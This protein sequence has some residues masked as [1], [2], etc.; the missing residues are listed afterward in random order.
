ML[1]VSI[2]CTGHIRSRIHF[3]SSCKDSKCFQ[4]SAGYSIHGKQTS[5]QLHCSNSLYLSTFSCSYD[6]LSRISRWNFK[7]LYL[8]YRRR[9]VLWFSRRDDGSTVGIVYISMIYY[10]LLHS[11]LSKVSNY[12]RSKKVYQFIFLEKSEKTQ[13]V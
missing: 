12:H 3:C 9:K 5:Y 6:I 13:I 11:R 2:F 1:R 7:Q 4:K 10:R 8:F